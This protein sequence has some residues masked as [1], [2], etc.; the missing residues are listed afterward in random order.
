MLF[1]S[2]VDLFAYI[3]IL[4]IKTYIGNNANLKF[5]IMEATLQPQV[6]LSILE[7]SKN[8]KKS[9][10]TLRSLKSNKDMTFKII[11]KKYND[12][13]YTHVYVEI[14]YLEFKYL[15]FYGTDGNIHKGGKVVESISAKAIS[16]LIRNLLSKK[17]EKINNSLELF[18][19]GK[20]V[21]C[22]RTLTDANSILSGIGP[23]C[24]KRH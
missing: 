4:I 13:L 12:I 3:Y 21:C 18:H 19:L 15:G 7:S 5:T 1:L 2:F 17:I 9:I 20:C 16:W 11:K 24:A 10:F 8:V 22:G 14:K 23:S 6:L